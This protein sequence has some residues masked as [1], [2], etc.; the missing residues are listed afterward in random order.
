MDSVKQWLANHS[1]SAKTVV[2]VWLFVSGLWAF[3]P[4]FK[5]YVYGIYAALPHGVHN[6]IAAVVIPG[7]IFWRTQKRTTVSAEVAPGASGAAAVVATSP[8]EQ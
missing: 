4:Q 1:I 8:K 3:S 7:L 5:D 6:F 2:T